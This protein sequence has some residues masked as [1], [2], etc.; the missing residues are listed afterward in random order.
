MSITYVTDWF[1]QGDGVFVDDIVVSTGEGTT[2]FE[3]DDIELV[4]GYA[5]VKDHKIL[6]IAFNYDR[7]DALPALLGRVRS[8]A[9]ER[10]YPEVVVHAASHEPRGSVLEGVRERG[11]RLDQVELEVERL[12]ERRCRDQ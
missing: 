8:E 4:R 12:E 3:E 11:G 10:A 5:F 7:P 6:E 1:G 2:S 9:L